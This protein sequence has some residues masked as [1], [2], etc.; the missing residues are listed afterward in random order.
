MFDFI[1]AATYF[2]L[3]ILMLFTLRVSIAR[4]RAISSGM[5]NSQPQDN[6]LRLVM[7]I[8]P[9]AMLLHAAALGNS[10]VGNGGLQ[11][12]FSHAAS[13]IALITLTLYWLF[14]LPNAKLRALLL[15]VLPFAVVASALPSLMREPAPLLYSEGAA[16]TA[17]RAHLVVAM[18]AYSL[19]AVAVLHACAMLAIDRF[20]HRGNLPAWISVLP[21]LMEM[22]RVLGLLI[23][24]V[25]VLMSATVLSGV[26]FSEVL[27][28]RPF[29]FAHKN[30]FGMASWFTFGALL[31]GRWRLGWRGA[32]AAKW[33]IAGF[34]FLLLSYFGSKFVLEV[35]LR[36]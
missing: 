2:A 18:L 30:I 25:F 11:M 36:R 16:T 29:R 17:F 28:N 19:A 10:M 21:S 32:V 6:P 14:A 13:L 27:F 9:L 23:L 34:A 4:T 24:L 3:T 7:L 31:M 1:V 15:L 12:G 8:A 22:E 33:A 20:L 5:Q 26:F 35:V